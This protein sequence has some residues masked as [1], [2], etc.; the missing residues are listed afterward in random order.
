M[1]SSL[2]CFS[3]TFCFSDEHSS[4]SQ[5]G[6]GEGSLLSCKVLLQGPLLPATDL[7]GLDSQ[8]QKAPESGSPPSVPASP[9]GTARTM[10]TLIQICI[11]PP[12]PRDKPYTML[13][14]IG[15]QN[16]PLLS[17]E[18]STILCASSGAPKRLRTVLRA[19]MW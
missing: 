13:R 1:S 3:G 10:H 5:Q 16:P 2:A 11:R 7:C 9:I 19:G 12:L 18:A 17:Q 15:S 8:M 6:R 14:Q 4:R